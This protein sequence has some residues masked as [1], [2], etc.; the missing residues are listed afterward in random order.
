MLYTYARGTSVTANEKP[1]A[2][3][4]TTVVGK[5]HRSNDANSQIFLGTMKLPGS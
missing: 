4:R 3:F 2:V 5:E 1:T